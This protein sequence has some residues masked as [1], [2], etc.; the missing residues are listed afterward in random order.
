MRSGRVIEHPSP[1]SAE[2]KERVQLHLWAFMTYYRVNFTVTFIY[3][4]EV[5]SNLV[6]TH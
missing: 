3:D 4:T 5:Y 1:F 2:V 6:S